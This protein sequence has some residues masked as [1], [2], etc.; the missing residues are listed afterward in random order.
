MRTVHNPSRCSRSI[1]PC[2][3]QVLYSMAGWHKVTIVVVH[4]GMRVCR[5][6]DQYNSI[7][8]TGCIVCVYGQSPQNANSLCAQ[9]TLLISGLYYTQNRHRRHT[10]MTSI[11]GLKASKTPKSASGEMWPVRSRNVLLLTN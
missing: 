6:W 3:K 2:T 4:W 7:W 11:S 10:K 1:G 5:G 8:S 9:S